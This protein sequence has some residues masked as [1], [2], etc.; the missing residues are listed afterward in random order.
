MGGSESR[1]REPR[2]AD[3]FADA[4][5]FGDPSTGAEAC[6][7]DGSQ[8]TNDQDCDDTNADV[9]TEQPK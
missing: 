7:A 5:G 9:Y 6:E 2:H 4:D 8:V 3:F 1:T